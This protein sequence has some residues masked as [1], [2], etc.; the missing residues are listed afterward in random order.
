M[1]SLASGFTDLKRK[2]STIFEEALR[3]FPI[4]AARRLRE[5]E[6]GVTLGEMPEM[7][8]VPGLM[9]IQV[10]DE[11]VRRTAGRKERCF[12]EVGGS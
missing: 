9:F 8:D 12:P 7:P 10:R 2:Q 1:E 4:G 5:N 3:E 11:D 6:A